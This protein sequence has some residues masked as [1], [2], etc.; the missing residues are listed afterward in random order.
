MRH[1]TPCAM[2][3]HA[4]C[5]TIAYVK[6]KSA[7]ETPALIVLH[8]LN[9]P[10]GCP[11]MRASMEGGARRRPTVNHT[12]CSEKTYLLIHACIYALRVG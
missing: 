5:Y 2:L 11:S 3:H 12:A 9:N 1:V 7:G 4:P 6:K 10:Y 8:H